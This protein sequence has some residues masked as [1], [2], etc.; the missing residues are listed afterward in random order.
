MTARPETRPWLGGPS[1][2]SSNE[3]IPTAT[4]TDWHP[5]PRPRSPRFGTRN[6]IYGS[7]ERL[8][9]EGNEFYFEE[10]EHM[11]SLRMRYN[12]ARRDYQWGRTPFTIGLRRP[13]GHTTQLYRLDDTTVS[14]WEIMASEE[15]HHLRNTQ[16]PPQQQPNSWLRRGSPAPEETYNLPPGAFHSRANA[17]G[18]PV[19]TPRQRPTPFGTTTRMNP[20]YVWLPERNT[21]LPR[22]YPRAVQIDERQLMSPLAGGTS[23]NSRSQC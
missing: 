9:P 15:Y 4:P 18:Y 21:W 12:S 3:P 2:P 5:T 20:F 7:Y 8:I 19:W 17:E 1:G 22:T 23:P 10:T 6:I 14:T 13:P 11:L 16:P